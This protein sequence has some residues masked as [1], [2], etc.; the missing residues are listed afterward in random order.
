VAINR[1]DLAPRRL[2]RRTPDIVF[3][4]FES[5]VPLLEPFRLVSGV[6]DYRLLDYDSPPEPIVRWIE[7]TSS[8]LKPTVVP[9]DKILDSE[10]VDHA[11]V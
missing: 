10:A 8:R 2:F 7:S 3:V 5:I 1:N 9:Y 11:L 4:P 6:R